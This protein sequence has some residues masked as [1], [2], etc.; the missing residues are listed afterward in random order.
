MKTELIQNNVKPIPTERK[1]TSEESRVDKVT[2]PSPIPMTTMLSSFLLA[3]IDP[4]TRPRIL[5]AIVSALP[6]GLGMPSILL[7]GALVVVVKLHQ[8]VFILIQLLKIGNHT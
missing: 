8:L 3:P 5:L 2:L 1:T 6:L 4:P 7:E